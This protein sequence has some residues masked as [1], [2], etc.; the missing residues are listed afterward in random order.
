MP[1]L[2]DHDLKQMDPTWQQRQPEETVRGLLVRALDDQRWPRKSEHSDEWRLCFMNGP[3]ERAPKE[4][5]A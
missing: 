3:E 5:R 4:R 2:T 1:N